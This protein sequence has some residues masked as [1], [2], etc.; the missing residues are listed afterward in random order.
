MIHTLKINPDSFQA[1]IDGDK[2]AEFRNN[3]RAYNAGDILV[4]QEWI[5][6]RYTGRSRKVLVT[7]AQGGYGIPAGHLMLSIELIPEE[8]GECEHTNTVLKDGESLE[9]KPHCK[10]PH[11]WNDPYATTYCDCVEKANQGGCDHFHVRLVT[12]CG[13][14][15]CSKCL[16]EFWPNNNPSQNVQINPDGSVGA[17]PQKPSEEEREWKTGVYRVI[18]I[19]AIHSESKLVH[20]ELERLA[21][22]L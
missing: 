18:C 4:L 10:H 2:K 11:S 13:V 6:E 22:F 5:P 9:A 19:L 8:K 21:K 7:H 3:D 20:D 14:W 1:I 12:G 17:V 16:V 15:K